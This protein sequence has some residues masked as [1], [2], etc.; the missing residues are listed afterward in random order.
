MEMYG[1]LRC[2]EKAAM[3]Q[4]VLIDNID[5]SSEVAAGTIRTGVISYNIT[6]EIEGRLQMVPRRRGRGFNKNNNNNDYQ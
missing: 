3:Y 6:P 4:P 1:D 5:D 2:D